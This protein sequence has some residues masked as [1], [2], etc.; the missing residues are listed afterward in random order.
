V[1]DHHRR[2]RRCHQA[3]NAVFVDRQ[4]R[5]AELDRSGRRR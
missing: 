2:M 3:R 1:A 5:H 4:R